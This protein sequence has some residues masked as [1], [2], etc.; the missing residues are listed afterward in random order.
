MYIERAV[1]HVAW[2][3]K[4]LV[5]FWHALPASAVLDW[6]EDVMIRAATKALKRRPYF[7]FLLYGLTSW[8]TQDQ[9]LS[10]ILNAYMNGFK[11]ELEKEL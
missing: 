8:T 5:C 3:A 1:D 11:M 6:I 7:R 4:P 10:G 9:Y 2:F